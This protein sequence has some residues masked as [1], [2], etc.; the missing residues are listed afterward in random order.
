MSETT[1]ANKIVV[2]NPKERI[3]FGCTEKAPEG[4]K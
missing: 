4:T 2:R 3:P 1:N